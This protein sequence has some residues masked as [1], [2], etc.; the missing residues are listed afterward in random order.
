[1]ATPATPEMMVEPPAAPT[2]ST[3]PPR[4]SNTTKGDMELCGRLP[5]L[6]K[7]ALL[8]GMWK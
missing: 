2:L 6:M 4:G 7:L 1:M 5:G 3:R 8:G